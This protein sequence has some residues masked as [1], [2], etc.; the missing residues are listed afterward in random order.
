M[1]L[2]VVTDSSA[3]LPEK[4]AKDLGITVVPLYVLFG[5]EV[6]RDRVDI[7][8]EEFYRK[9]REDAVHPSTTQPS[10][11]DF[12]AVYRELSRGADGIISIHISGKLSG[13]VNSALRGRDIASVGPPVEVIDSL[14][15][16]MGLG[17]LVLGA[18]RLAKNGAAFQEAVDK[19]RNGVKNIHLLGLLDT[20]KYV[21]RGGRIGKAKTLLGTVLSVKPLLTLEEGETVPAGQVRSRARGIDRLFSFVENTP[22]VQEAA[23]VYNTTPDEARELVDRISAVV[24]AG[25]IHL[26]TVGPVLGVHMGPGALIV[27]LRQDQG[28]SV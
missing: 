22:G 7:S 14:T 17:L 11:Q 1:V 2:K 27:A 19:T 12:A 6:Y 18:A 28:P 24:P 3:D 4:L 20:L 9:L 21:A 10:P 26:A 5:A 8:E 13:T 15:L 16:T 23:V 25:R